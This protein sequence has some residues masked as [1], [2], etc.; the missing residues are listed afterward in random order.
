MENDCRHP[1]VILKDIRFSEIKAILEYMY[2]GEVNVAQD[3]LAG[4][5][6]AAET[7]KVKGLVEDNQSVS[8]TPT[9]P[10][11]PMY[12][13]P[14]HSTP[15]FH[16][17]SYSKSNCLPSKFIP[18]DGMY[19]GPY[20][21]SSM[22]ERNPLPFPLWNSSKF[23]SPSP[24]SNSSGN[25]GAGGNVNANSAGGTSDRIDRSDRYENSQN[26]PVPLKKKKFLGATKDTPIL[27]TVLGHT[28]LQ[29]NV[30]SQPK[31]LNYSVPSNASNGPS[32]HNENVKHSY[33]YI[34]IDLLLNSFV[35]LSSCDFILQIRVESPEHF[36]DDSGR[37]VDSD[38][39]LL[40][41]VMIMHPNIDDKKIDGNSAY[42]NLVG[43]NVYI[44]F[45]VWQRS[46]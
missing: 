34:L 8:G 2:K 3:Q 32:E 40:T 27:R 13:P 18:G 4:L 38:K 16:P 46:S 12:P 25:G 11:Q 6:K 45:N 33:Q 19:E 23:V 5:L 30:E 43:R 28:S 17:V 21:A 24:K 15:D 39:V 35:Y 42:I 36:M 9:P 31:N 10:H 41:C 29:A 37:S 1:I 44:L 20:N 7:L 26:E 14:P 22:Q